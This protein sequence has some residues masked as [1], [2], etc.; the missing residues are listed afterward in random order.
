MHASAIQEY[1][2]LQNA[3]MASSAMVDYRYDKLVR[4]ETRIDLWNAV[5]NFG[6]NQAVSR[7]GSLVGSGAESRGG[8]LLDM[9]HYSVAADAAVHWWR[10]NWRRAMKEGLDP[11]IL[12]MSL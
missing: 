11:E 7:L 8:S 5:I 3:C 12:S 4:L 2:D 6:W 10:N 1:K 9:H